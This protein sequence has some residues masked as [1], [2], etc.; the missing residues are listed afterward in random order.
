MSEIQ[1]EVVRSNLT[2][3]T[4]QPGG[5]NRNGKIHW[6][7]NDPTTPDLALDVDVPVA[8]PNPPF[9]VQNYVGY[10]AD[11]NSNQYRAANCHVSLLSVQKTIEKYVGTL[12]KWRAV[13]IMKIIPHAGNQLNAYYDRVS[14]RFFSGPN[15]VTRSW[16]H[17]SLSN[18]V[19]SHEWGHSLMDSYR[20]DLWGSPLI[21]H[22]AAHESFGDM[23]SIIHLMNIDMILT[24]MADQIDR[25]ET[26]TVVSKV[27]E[28][29]GSAILR[30][31][32]ALRDAAIPV[33]YQ[34]PESL[35]VRGPST[36]LIR[37]P[38][39]FSRIF[40]SAFYASILAITQK[41]KATGKTTKEALAE[42]RDVMARTIL[43]AVRVAPAQPRFLSSLANSVLTVLKDSPYS[44]DVG[45]VMTKWGLT[46]VSAMSETPS[47]RTL[48]P[49]DRK[50][51]VEGQ[52]VFI[53]DR[54]Q[55]IVVASQAIMSLSENPLYFCQVD[56]PR[57]ELLVAQGD[58]FSMSESA[59]E[60][61]I[62]DE[63]ILALDY[64]W[65][66]DLVAL[67]GQKRKD[68]HT[69][70]VEVHDGIQILSRVAYNCDGCFDNANNPQAPEF[71]KGWKRANNSGC[72]SGCNKKIEPPAPP[73][74]LGCFINERT[75]GSR[76]VRSCQVVR[77]KVC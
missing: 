21:E 13:Q 27:G 33:F 16:C 4:P 43:A 60:A 37:D 76:S 39:S 5:I 15:A 45:N 17:T 10:A 32:V 11:P 59:D 55:K 68:H 48:L 8:Q 23:I 1:T 25:G 31:P 77:Q 6:F 44:L 30:S 29:I 62:L 69:F 51:T 42:A 3:P 35:P 40:T 22:G 72:C 49:T 71:K 67:D 36:Q 54:S 20:P 56:V 41:V 14:L 24:R 34:R 53:R 47:V 18:D 63:V 74:K 64:I 26:S 52:E 19:V 57:Q 50:E 65:E 7:L 75:C 38:H 28:D 58:G 70:K 12:P 73:P 66:Q 61:E 46:G 2:R 9:S